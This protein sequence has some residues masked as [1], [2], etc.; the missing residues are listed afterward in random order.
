MPGRTTERRRRALF[1][2]TAFLLVAGASIAYA[3]I[4][5]DMIASVIRPILVTLAA[6]TFLAAWNDAASEQNERAELR[7]AEQGSL[8]LR[9]EAET[10]LVDPGPDVWHQFDAHG[11]PSTEAFSAN[12]SSVSRAVSANGRNFRPLVTV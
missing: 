10:V 5:E 3:Q 11:L 7:I 2:I 1:M 12:W 6:F 9:T 8:L 4:R